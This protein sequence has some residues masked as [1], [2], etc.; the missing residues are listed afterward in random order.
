MGKVTTI[1]YGEKREWASREGAFGFFYEAMLTCEGC[2]RYRC[3][4]IVIKLIRG[5]KVCSD[6]D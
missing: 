4:T 6:E 5:L 2:E 3:A 1:F